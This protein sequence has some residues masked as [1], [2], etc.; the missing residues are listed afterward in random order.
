MSWRMQHRYSSRRGTSP[1]TQ[2]KPWK[3][4]NSTTDRPLSPPTFARNAGLKLGRFL[5]LSSSGGPHHRDPVPSSSNS[6]RH[7]QR[8]SGNWGGLVKA[9]PILCFPKHF[10]YFTKS[11]TYLF[12]YLLHGAESFLRS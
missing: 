4:S 11:I 2:K 8:N 1:T 12:T 6:P 10:S 5:P 7:G 3:T 9:S